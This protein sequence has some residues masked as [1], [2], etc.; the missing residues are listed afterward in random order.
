MIN[1]S[2]L[3]KNNVITQNQGNIVS[4]MDGELVMLSIEKGNYYN[5]GV[6]GGEIWSLIEKPIKISD[7]LDKLISQYDVS[8]QECEEEVLSFL[9]DLYNEGLI[10]LP[11]EL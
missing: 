10:I 2:V 11:A 7:L 3:S 5:L 4:D 1:A 8:Q 9:S 6:L